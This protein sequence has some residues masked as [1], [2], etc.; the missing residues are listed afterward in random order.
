MTLSKYLETAN[1]KYKLQQKENGKDA[2]NETAFNRVF[3]LT[4]GE[5]EYTEKEFINLL[6]VILS[7]NGDYNALDHDRMRLTLSNALHNH[8]LLKIDWRG[9]KPQIKESYEVWY[10]LNTK[11]LTAQK[12]N[13]FDDCG[14]W[15]KVRDYRILDG[16]KWC[17]LVEK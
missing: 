2:I 8:Y 15:V 3:L 14:E 16:V 5:C 9:V 6:L 4:I 1:E 11:E 12:H 10:N 7:P 17:D 13:D